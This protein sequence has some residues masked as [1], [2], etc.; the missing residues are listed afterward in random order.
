M[1][2]TSVKQT[3]ILKRERSPNAPAKQSLTASLNSA[4]FTKHGD[5]KEDYE[6]SVV[7]TMGKANAFSKWK[8][9]NILIGLHFYSEMLRH[10]SGQRGSFP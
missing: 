2:T 7:Q 9:L 5:R 3:R 6:E 4:K 10:G 1:Q 8:D